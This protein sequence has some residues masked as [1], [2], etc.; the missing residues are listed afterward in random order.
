LIAGTSYS[1]L[2]TDVA[3]DTDD[4]SCTI[5]ATLGELDLGYDKVTDSLTLRPLIAA[6]PE[7]ERTILTLRFFGELTQTQIAQR[8]GCSQM[9]VS[10]LLAKA[11]GALRDQLLDAEQSALSYQPSTP[12]PAPQKQHR[13]PAPP[14]QR[15]RS[16]TRRTA[17]ASRGND[18]RSARRKIGN[19]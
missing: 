19:P 2:S 8:I 16:R 5:S 18:A 13:K 10:R 7:R 12:T 6:M 15:H 11:V 1:T 17:L 4:E 14:R 9:H 3:R